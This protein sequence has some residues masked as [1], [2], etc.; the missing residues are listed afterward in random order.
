MSVFQDLLKEEIK[1]LIELKEKY[2]KEIGSFPKGSLSSKIRN[3]KSYLYLA[4]RKK[5]KVKFE[6][7]G[8]EDSKKV[9]KIRELIAKRQEISNKLK[10]V[11]K[12]LR[13]LKKS[14]N[15]K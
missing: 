3:G 9:Q 15:E 7:I 2:E 8:K 5:K 13:E 4:Y 12:E 1:R 11:N 6:Y 14:V 10:Q